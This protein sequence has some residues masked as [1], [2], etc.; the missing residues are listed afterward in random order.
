MSEPISPDDAPPERLH[1]LFLASGI[2]GSLRQLAGGYVALGYLAVSGRLGTALVIA[3]LL[4]VVGLIG[5]FLYWRRFGFRVGADEIRID[6]GIFSRTHRS[7]PFDRIQD[8]DITQGAIARLLGIAAVRF[9]TGGASGGGQD[10]GMLRA[11]PIDRAEAIRRI[12]RGYRTQDSARPAVEATAANDPVFAMDLPRVGLAGLFNFSL[13]I[14]AGL[15]GLTQTLGD[16]LGFNPFTE[17]FWRDVLARSGPVAGFLAAHRAAAVAGGVVV[18]LIAGALTGLTRTVLREFGFRL[19]RTDTSLRRRRGLLTRTDVSLPVRRVQAALI[20]TGPIRDAF[21]WRVLKLQNLAQDEGSGDHVVAPLAS[22][23][24]VAAIVTELGW[25]PLPDRPRWHRVSPAYIWQLLVGVV[26][27]AALALVL[28]LVLTVGPLQ[29]DAAAREGVAQSLLPL[30]VAS[31][32]VLLFLLAVTLS[33]VLGW[34]RTGFLLDGDR[35]LVRTGWWRRQLRILPLAKIQSVEIAESF[36]GRWF[37]V[38]TLIFGVA[39]GRGFSAHSIP[40]VPR[41]QAFHLRSSLLDS[42]A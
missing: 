3:A 23:P 9:E 42:P 33:R 40:A 22:D 7:I 24:E 11:I 39:G 14:F 6:S 1:P 4:V 29:I 18:L 20:S 10:D 38:T 26:P 16:V 25:R 19:D 36:F 30:V 41:L 12:V 5:T 15:L 31:A 37:G 8:V 21:G 28:L 35:L 32:L 2:A 27:L 13:A 17:I 34:R